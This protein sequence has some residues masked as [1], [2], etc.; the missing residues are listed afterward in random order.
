MALRD[1]GSFVDSSANGL[2]AVVQKIDPIYVRFN[3]SE[4]DL[5]EGPPPGREWQDLP[6]P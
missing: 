3:V 1:V 2:L 4:K 6:G 5:L